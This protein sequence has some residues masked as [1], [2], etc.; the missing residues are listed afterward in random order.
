MIYLRVLFLN[1]K[2]LPT[3]Y[4]LKNSFRNFHGIIANLT[5]LI[6]LGRMLSLFNHLDLTLSGLIPG[7]PLYSMI[8]DIS[9]NDLLYATIL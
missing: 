7:P 6:Y 5:I 9:C 8:S 1:D 3:L 2:K 4:P